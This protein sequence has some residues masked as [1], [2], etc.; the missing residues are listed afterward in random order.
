MNTARQAID[1]LIS[2]LAE[3][4]YIASEQIATTL[5]LARALQRPILIEGPPGVGKTELANASAAMLK[6]PLFRL[7]CY[8]GLDESKALYDWKYSKQL[9][10]VQVL[11]EQLQGIL[12]GA[13]DLSA[14]VERLH[15]FD[16]I[17]YSER[18]L[19]PRP[20]LSAL[21]SDD[22]AVL[23]IDEIDK[24]DYEFESLL[25]EILADFAVTLPEIGTLRAKHK[26]L[27]LLT[28]NNTRDL[29]D[30]L[31]RRCLHLYIPFPEAELES[32]IVQSR[33]PDVADS[34]R[35]QLVTFVHGV[36]QL[37][38]KKQPAISETIDWARSLLLLH[39]DSLSAAL[40]DDSLNV[41]L[42]YEEDINIVRPEI[43][44]LLS[45]RY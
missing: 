10:Y 30:A 35:Q 40:V 20:L 45:Q 43:T 38:L 22:G 26:P 9:L 7:Q 17:F 44:R 11:K 25:L 23:L 42:K 36:R 1:E 31:K 16:D 34:L 27:V 4:G 21:Q 39:A 33:V 2:Q 13:N 24:A 14:A 32:R 3:Q 15:N 6:L 8:E 37:D 18:F 12:G 41:L 29:S 28:S 5:H 19:E